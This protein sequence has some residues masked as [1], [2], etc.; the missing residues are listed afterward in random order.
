MTL[1]RSPRPAR[2]IGNADLAAYTQAVV[3]DPPRPRSDHDRQQRSQRLRPAGRLHLLPTGPA[4]PH[5]PGHPAA[6][7]RAVRRPWPWWWCRCGGWRADWPGCAPAAALI[8]LLVYAVH[9][10]VQTLN[11][12]GFHPETLA[13]PF[14]VAAAYFGLS[15]ALASLRPVL[16]HRHAVPRRS[17]PGHRRARRPAHRAGPPPAGRASPIAVGVVWAFGFLFVLQ[18]HIGHAGITQLDA[19]SAYGD[20]PLSVA[21]GMLTPP[22]A[23]AGQHVQR[24]ELPADGLP[25]RAG[26]VPAVPVAALPASGDPPP[27]P[28]PGRQRPPGDPVRAPGGG[29]HRVHLPGHADG[30]G[31]PR[32]A[33]RREGDRRPARAHHRAVGLHLVLRADRA[34]HAVPASRGTGA[35]ATPVDGAR[36]EARESMSRTAPC[37]PARRC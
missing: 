27:A 13:L 17:G 6:A 26:A 2:S 21:W 4:E 33:Q 14:L 5:H 30:T 3:A 28:L 37:G 15:R 35:A 32:S 36:L 31:P 29:D 8:V 16:P 9:P 34:Q 20:T 23:G 10:I 22:A 24:V 18:P 1:C 19:Y 11:L 12:D 7:D 25:V